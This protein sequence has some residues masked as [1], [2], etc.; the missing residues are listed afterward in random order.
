MF[1]CIVMQIFWLFSMFRTRKGMLKGNAFFDLITWAMTFINSQ[2]RLWIALLSLSL[3]S[4]CV[5]CV[6]G[7]TRPS[8]EQLRLHVGHTLTA[9]HGFRSQNRKYLMDLDPTVQ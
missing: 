1:A 9:E 4:L 3:C 5:C 2:T 8:I 7:K 6:L